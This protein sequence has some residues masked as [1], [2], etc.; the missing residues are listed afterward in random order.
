MNELKTLK[1]LSFEF[2]GW[3]WE[4][5]RKDKQGNEV[6][7]DS[8]NLSPAVSVNDLRVESINWIKYYLK[9]LDCPIENRSVV[10]INESKE[11]VKTQ[12]AYS[13]DE[14]RILIAYIIKFFNSSAEDLK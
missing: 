6:P 8:S 9:Q 3:E 7:V 14:I 11:G 5:W 1:E 13:D 4:A 12:R 10:I 2:G